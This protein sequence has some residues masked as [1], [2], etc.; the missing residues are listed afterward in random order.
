MIADAAD[1]YRFL[2]RDAAGDFLEG[3]L[4]KAQDQLPVGH[5]DQDL[6]NAELI[7]LARAIKSL[8]RGDFSSDI[9]A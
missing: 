8:A 2:D 1:V 7:A 9:S 5:V 4:E 6:I 3:L